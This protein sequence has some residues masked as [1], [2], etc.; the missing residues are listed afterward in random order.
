MPWL[1]VTGMLISMFGGLLIAP[2]AWSAV[3]FVLAV[4]LIAV[5]VRLEEQ[6]LLTMHGAAYAAYAA[7]VGRFVPWVGRLEQHGERSC[8]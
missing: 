3:V 7:R 6:H 4:V 2:A 5:Q 1:P 8:G